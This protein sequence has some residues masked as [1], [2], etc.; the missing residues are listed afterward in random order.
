MKKELGTAVYMLRH[1]FD[2]FW[3]MKYAGR[4]SLGMAVGL[5][6]LYF[7]TVIVDLQARSFMFNDHYNT[8]LDLMYQLRVF[9]CR[10]RCFW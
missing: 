6:A 1:P 4:G 5:M 8:A 3:E 2:G 9:C 7:V 10:W